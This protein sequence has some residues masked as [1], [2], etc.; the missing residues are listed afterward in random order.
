[1]LFEARGPHVGPEVG[2]PGLSGTVMIWI[3][4]NVARQVALVLE[5]LA[6]SPIPGVGSARVT[7]HVHQR[8]NGDF[9][10][11]EAGAKAPPRELLS[12]GLIP[13]ARKPMT[14]PPHGPSATTPRSEA[15]SY[16]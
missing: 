12:W 8:L 9:T 5:W 10:E 11:C 2:R 15:W 16:R 7:R 3:R 14:N 4:A 13:T 6:S 1:M